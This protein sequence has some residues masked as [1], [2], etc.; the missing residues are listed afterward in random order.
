[1]AL[2]D[3]PGDVEEGFSAASK[4]GAQRSLN[5]LHNLFIPPVHMT[6]I[7]RAWGHPF[8][9]RAAEVLLST[10]SSLLN[11]SRSVHTQQHIH[12]VNSSGTGKSR[13]VDEVA[14][15]VITVPMC[16]RE[17]GNQGF[18]FFPL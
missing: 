10:L 13:M 5:T 17:V 12:V 6:A 2:Q 7:V 15:T 16:L 3:S 11:K 1:M 14:K 8:K 4:D 9:G 18:L